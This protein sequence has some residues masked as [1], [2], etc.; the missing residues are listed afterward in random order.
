ML[1]VVWGAI[2][3]GASNV[4]KYLTKESPV[5]ATKFLLVLLT[6]HTT[7]GVPVELKAGTFA[8]RAMVD[9][10]REGLCCQKET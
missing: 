10:A 5:G 8:R 4:P 1:V 7:E 2:A 3:P 9:Q 6:L